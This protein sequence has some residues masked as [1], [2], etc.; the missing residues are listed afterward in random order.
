L[1]GQSRSWS[2][3]AHAFTHTRSEE[4]E[5]RELESAESQLLGRGAQRTARVGT[6][7]KKQQRP[8]AVQQAARAHRHAARNA[9]PHEQPSK[10]RV[11]G[12]ARHNHFHC[13]GEALQ[14]LV[15]AEPDDMQTHNLRTGAHSHSNTFQTM[16]SALQR[17]QAA[18][19]SS[20]QCRKNGALD[21]MQDALGRGRQR[22]AAAD[23]GY[24]KLECSKRRRGAARVPFPPCPR[25]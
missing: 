13:D 12:T 25:K 23:E 2:R 19:R 22:Q 4:G 8:Q 3:P 24:G 20:E 21:S 1:C 9:T 16:S 7:C 10:K 17:L 11:S 14:H 15:C 5:R 6:S 18:S